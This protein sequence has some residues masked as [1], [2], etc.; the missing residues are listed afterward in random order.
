MLQRSRRAKRRRYRRYGY[1]KG[2][3]GPPA[4]DRSR[5]IIQSTDQQDTGLIFCKCGE[6]VKYAGRPIC[7]D[8]FVNAHVRWPGRA[9]RARIL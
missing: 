2:R 1:S 4:P 8:C 6:V 7:E 9:T 5:K 3:S